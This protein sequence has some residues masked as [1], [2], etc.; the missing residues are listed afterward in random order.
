MADIEIKGIELTKEQKKEVV[1]RLQE[2]FENDSKGL[3]TEETVNE[4]EIRVKAQVTSFAE[5]TKAVETI[6]KIEK[7]H[8]CNCTLLEV[9]NTASYLTRSEY[10]R[11]IKKNTHGHRSSDFATLGNVHTGHKIP[12]VFENFINMN[13]HTKLMQPKE[14]WNKFCNKVDYFFKTIFE[15]TLHIIQS[16]LS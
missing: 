15:S 8:S 7:E 3:T 13:D 6:R 12:S 4:M 2:N 5:I 11:K 16:I 1:R 10:E 14:L 9:E